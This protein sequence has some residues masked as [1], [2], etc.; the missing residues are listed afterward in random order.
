MEIGFGTQQIVG[1]PAAEPEAIDL[2]EDPECIRVKRHATLFRRRLRGSATSLP[3][4][5]AGLPSHIRQQVQSVL[6]AQ[7]DFVNRDVVRRLTLLAESCG[8]GV[9]VPVR[10]C[11]KL[12]HVLLQWMGSESLNVHRHRRRQTL[13]PKGAK[14][15]GSAVW[16]GQERKSILCPRLVAGDQRCV[17][18]YGG[19]WPREHSDFG[20]R[21]AGGARQS[22]PREHQ[23]EWQ[24][25][26]RK[27]QRATANPTRGKAAFSAIL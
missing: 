17:V 8:S 6:W 7:S 14:P 15:Q 3:G 22:A 19:R 12:A 4:F 26:N 16:V 13:G 23:R 25:G 24:C 10:P 27:K 18:L 5:P 20:F 9:D 11:V 2:L 1:R 21:I